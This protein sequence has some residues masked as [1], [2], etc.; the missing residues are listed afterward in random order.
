M[1]PVVLA[2]GSFL[3][4]RHE[5][6]HGFDGFPHAGI[7]DGGFPVIDTSTRSLARAFG[8]APGAILLQDRR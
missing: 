2:H 6:V 4:F 8:I 5:S 1:K 7:G 3:S